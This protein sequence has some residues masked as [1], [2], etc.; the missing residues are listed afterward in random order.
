MRPEVVG[1]PQVDDLADHVGVSGERAEVWPAGPIAEPVQS[2]AFVASLPR[3]EA[4]AV[5]P[6]VA[7]GCETLPVTSSACCKIASR[8]FA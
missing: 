5:D 8:R 4:L 3:V 7:A 2:L 1:L 6:V